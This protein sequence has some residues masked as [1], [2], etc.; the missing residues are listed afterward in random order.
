M[1]NFAYL[2]GKR[3]AKACAAIDPGWDAK[4]IAAAARKEGLTIE[5]IL[6]THT[7][8]D[9]ATEV[10]ALAAETGAATYVHHSEIGEIPGNV[11][12]VATDDGTIIEVGVLKIKC[13][14]T[15]GHTPGSQ[16]FETNGAIFTGDTLFVEGCG[17]VDLPGSDPR[18][19]ILSLKKLAAL[20]PKI[21]IYPGHDYG[22]TPTS[23]IGDEVKR[24][25]YMSLDS[26]AMLL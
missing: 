3:G 22:P 18:Q 12:T 20:D 13:L 5:K 1:M 26:E 6:L 25:P 24:N 7:H 15:P 11:K 23:T 14:H 17:R 16:C 4:S 9:H 10:G 2:V 21:V 8:F 19:M